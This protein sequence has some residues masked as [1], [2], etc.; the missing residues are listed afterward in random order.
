MI[1]VTTLD[2]RDDFS[3]RGPIPIDDTD[4]EDMNISLHQR[5]T[6]IELLYQ[7]IT[8]EREREMFLD[9]L[10]SMS[11]SD[12]EDLRYSLLTNTWR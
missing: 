1:N 9:S 5:A 3:S 6:L 4:F 12:A 10:D 7:K 2:T 8:D 11:R